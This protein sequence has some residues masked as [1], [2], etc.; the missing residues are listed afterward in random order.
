MITQPTRG[1]GS[2]KPTASCASSS[3]WRIRVVSPALKEAA[4]ESGMFVTEGQGCRR[5]GC[6]CRAPQRG[7]RAHGGVSGGRGSVNAPDSA[8]SWPAINVDRRHCCAVPWRSFQCRVTCTALSAGSERVCTDAFER[9]GGAAGGGRHVDRGIGN[10][11]PARAVGEAAQRFDIDLRQPHR[12][13]ALAGRIGTGAQIGLQA[14]QRE[15][16]ERQG[17]ERE[18]GFEQRDAALPAP[19]RCVLRGAS[20]RPFIQKSRQLPGTRVKLPRW[21]CRRARTPAS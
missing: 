20:D 5:G 7:G 12:F 19:Q 13:G 11:V 21:P 3:A 1:L 15:H 2:L 14:R 18:Q 16:A 8:G 9:V 6:D 17:Q 4:G 10:R